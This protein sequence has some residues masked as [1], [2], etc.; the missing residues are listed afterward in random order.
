M[1]ELQTFAA[2][3]PLD[4]ALEGVKN[5]S[6]KVRRRN[7]NYSA[8][9]EEQYGV[10]VSDETGDLM[11]RLYSAVDGPSL[12]RAIQKLGLNEADDYEELLSGCH[13][14]ENDD[15]N[16]GRVMQELDQKLHASL[17]DRDKDASKASSKKHR[18]SVYVPNLINDMGESG[19]VYMAKSLS[20]TSKVRIAW[21]LDDENVV[22]MVDDYDKWEQLLG[23]EKLKQFPH[24]KNQIREQYG[25]VL[26]DDVL[27]MVAAD[28]TSGGSSDSDDSGSTGR[29]TRTKPTDELLNVARGS[30]HR[31][32]FKQ[33]SEYIVDGFDEDGYIGSEYSPVKMLVLFPTTTDLNMTD[34]W[35]V[36]GSRWGGDSGHVSIANCNKGTFEYLNQRDEVCHIE[37]YLEQAGDY[38]FETNHG[39]VTLDS[40]SRDKLVLHVVEPETKSKMLND[41]VCDNIPELL[42]PYMEDNLYSSPELPHHDD[43]LYAPITAEEA[44]WMR[45]ELH[46]VMKDDPITILYD[47]SSPRDIGKKYN[48]SS[49]FE[50]YARA[51]LPDWDFDSVEMETLDS[52]SYKLNLDKGGYEL[53]ETLAMLHDNGQKPF[54]QTP[55]ARWSQ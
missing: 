3:D 19:T 50:L 2:G 35:W 36:A 33:K 1:S 42:G 46:D 22:L 30:S 40:V 21:D 39:P 54:S 34:H 28:S 49:D 37:D 43:M 15:T 41:T 7:S 18:D 9:I 53:V 13:L 26:S 12:I 8:A 31:K 4:Y 47:G 24:G 45:P 10:R 27:D 23:W 51:R 14:D 6:S 25:D 55:K 32:R 29:A 5:T 20:T 52:A 38:E 11:E 16:L 44:F 48:L 17:A